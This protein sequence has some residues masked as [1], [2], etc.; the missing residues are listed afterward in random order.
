MI[1]REASLDVRQAYIRRAAEDLIGRARDLGLI[2]TIHLEPQ[3][4]PA[5]RH[6]EPV[7]E[8]REAR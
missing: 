3:Q 2:V 4:P 8:V 5:M 6:Y 7:V 1:A